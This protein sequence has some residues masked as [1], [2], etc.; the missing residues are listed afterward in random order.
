MLISCSTLVIVM[1]TIM[2]KFNARS[3]RGVLG[4]TLCDKVCQ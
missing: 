2:S 4:T 3:C 1:D